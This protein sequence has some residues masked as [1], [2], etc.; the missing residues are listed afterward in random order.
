VVLPHVDEISATDLWPSF[1]VDM[2]FLHKN[3]KTRTIKRRDLAA[4]WCVIER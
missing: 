3:T 2:V 1:C 4:I